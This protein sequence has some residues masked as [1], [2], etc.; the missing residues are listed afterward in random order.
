MGTEVRISRAHYR[1]DV[2]GWKESAPRTH[3]LGE[4]GGDGALDDVKAL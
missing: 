4:Y 3:L 1:G 2:G